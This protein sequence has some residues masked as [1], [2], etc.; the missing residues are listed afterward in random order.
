MIIVRNN[1]VGR[2][3]IYEWCKLSTFQNLSPLPDVEKT[4]VNKKFIINTADQATLTINFY[5]NFNKEDQIKIIYAPFR[6]LKNSIT[7]Y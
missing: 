4:R 5:K 2:K 3:F 6:S 7:K 1:K